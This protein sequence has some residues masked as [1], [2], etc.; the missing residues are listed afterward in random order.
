MNNKLKIF[1]LILTAGACAL[2][3]CMVWL[4]AVSIL[5]EYFSN[6][7]MFEA[8]LFASTFLYT[9]GLILIA[10]WLILSG[11]FLKNAKAKKGGIFLLVIYFAFNALSYGVSFFIEPRNSTADIPQKGGEIPEVVVLDSVEPAEGITE[12]EMSKEFLSN[13]SSFIK[14]DLVDGVRQYLESQNKHLPDD[15]DISSE[16]FYI[17][18][19]DKKL[20]VVRFNIAGSANGLVVLGIKGD[21]LHRILCN[22]QSVEKISLMHGK[23]ANRISEIFKV[24]FTKGVEVEHL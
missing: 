7:R 12:K 3:I 18:A 16:S 22:N 5:H 6:K 2:I 13:Y 24:D 11:V 1:G 4:L 8:E 9:I 10:A 19:S 20:A 23:C 17:N 14:E 15:F 21:K